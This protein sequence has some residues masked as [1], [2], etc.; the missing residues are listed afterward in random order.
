[1]YIKE[2]SHVGPTSQSILKPLEFL[3]S[4]RSNILYHSLLEII[5]TSL[6][7]AGHP[8]HPVLQMRCTALAL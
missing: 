8:G 3:E 1:M 4:L 2:M 6:W 7:L 5:R